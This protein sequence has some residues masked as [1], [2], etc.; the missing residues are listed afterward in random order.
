[1]IS[2]DAKTKHITLTKGDTLRLK[3][4]LKKD[5]GEY[6]PEEGDS[7]FFYCGRLDNRLVLSEEINIETGELYL[8]SSDTKKLNA[9][10]YFYD[11]EYVKANGDVDTII[12]RAKLTIVKEV[13]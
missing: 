1:M 6:T 2:V 5:G 11:V 3:I 8:N 4:S 9:G 13:G 7:L 12:N 10:D